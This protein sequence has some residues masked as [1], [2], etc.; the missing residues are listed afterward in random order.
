LSHPPQCLV[1]VEPRQPHPL[2]AGSAAFALIDEHYVM[3]LDD[4]QADV[5]LTTR[6]EHGA[7]PAGWTRQ[8]LAGR[9]CV[10]SPGHNLD[11]WLHPSY[12]ALIG[13]ALRWCSN[14]AVPSRK[15]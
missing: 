9:V 15:S 13:N 14:T 7:Q 12:Q 5:F 11:V 4:A 10:L 2:T 6:S 8:E 3:A 1:A